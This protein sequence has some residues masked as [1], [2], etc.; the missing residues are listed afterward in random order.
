MYS[1][2]R[3]DRCNPTLAGRGIGVPLATPQLTKQQAS[4]V[5]DAM[6]HIAVAALGQLLNRFSILLFQLTMDH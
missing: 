1:G 6:H 3:I 2:C 5:V 4:L